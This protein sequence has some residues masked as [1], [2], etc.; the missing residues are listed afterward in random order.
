MS[1]FIKIP[2]TAQMEKDYAE[3]ARMMDEGKEKD[4]D[5]CSLNGGAFECLGECAWCEDL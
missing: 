5:T 1:K 3:C 4:C 2:L